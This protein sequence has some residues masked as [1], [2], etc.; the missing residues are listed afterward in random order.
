MLT[1]YPDF[2]ASAQ[3]ISFSIEGG[4]AL[5]VLRASLQDTAGGY[6]DADLNLAERIEN[7]NGQFVFNCKY[8]HLSVN[9]VLDPNLTLRAE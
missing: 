7:S 5:P 3:N 1:I 2:A 9:H 8:S 4:G 6:V